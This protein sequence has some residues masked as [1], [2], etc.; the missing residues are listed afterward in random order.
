MPVEV[1]SA[2]IGLGGAFVGVPDGAIPKAAES[3]FDDDIPF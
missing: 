1:L 3:S 2:L